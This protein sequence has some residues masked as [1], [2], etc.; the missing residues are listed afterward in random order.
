MH[1]LDGVVSGDSA[2]H[3]L[4]SI[5]GCAPC[6][7]MRGRAHTP[8][9]LWHRGQRLRR[10]LRRMLLPPCC[11]SPIP[12]TLDEIDAHIQLFVAH[13]TVL[14]TKRNTLTPIDKLPNE[15]L[16]RILRI[17]AHISDN[18]FSAGW[19][20]TIMRVC[21]RWYE[22]AMAEQSL[23]AYLDVNTLSHAR[24]TLWTQLA[25]AGA[26][27]LTMRVSLY[28]RTGDE[29]DVDW[30]MDHAERTGAFDVGGE[31]RLVLYFLRELVKHQIP[32]LRSLRLS[33]SQLRSLDVSYVDFPWDL[34]ANLDSLRIRQSGNSSSPAPP[35]VAELID[36]LSRCP[37]LHDL[38]LEV[39]SALTPY[40]EGRVTHLPRLQILDFAGKVSNAT[41]LQRSL[42]IP[43]TANVDLKLY[44]VHDGAGIRD[45]IVPL[46][47]HLRGAAP[48]AR[49]FPTLMLDTMSGDHTGASFILLFELTTAGKP[50]SRFTEKQNWTEPTLRQIVIKLLHAAQTEHI[51]HLDASR[52][53][54]V[55]EASWKAILRNL[56]ALQSIQ[57]APHEYNLAG[58]TRSVVG[59]LGA[60]V[61]LAGDAPQITA[62]RMLV[63]RHHTVEHTSDHSGAWLAPVVS[64]LR[65]ARARAPLTTLDI[66]DEFSFTFAAR[67][68]NIMRRMF[69]LLTGMGGV[70]RRRKSEVWDPS[71]DKRRRRERKRTWREMGI[72]NISETSE[73]SSSED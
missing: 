64:A 23:W 8:A 42:R 72:E 48:N 29:Y 4:G 37:D 24:S 31:A 17:Y 32:Q 25:R 73:S 50:A 30:M 57:L 51:T 20:K 27:P 10:L 15:L 33:G 12:D 60:L 1:P 28:E 61:A 58:S 3:V 39:P 13:L 36:L 55:G 59:I 69:R 49:P 34:P 53:F 44:G 21:R 38:D 7:T 68:K 43:W 41:A 47:P 40:T 67:Y 56:P 52:V 45:F 2:L 65:G 71:E 19:S 54:R 14:K 66:D 62:L 26:A 11:R 46:C 22:L 18:L 6:V 63:V 35:T 9:A 70:F 5:F 16:A